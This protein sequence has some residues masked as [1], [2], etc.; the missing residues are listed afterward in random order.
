V[1]TA[2]FF[3]LDGTLLTRE[4]PFDAVLAATFEAELGRVEADWLARYERRFE[5]HA[6]AFVPDPHERALADVCE[7]FDL[8]ADPGALAE[9]LAETDR[10]ATRVSD[11]AVAA[12]RKLGVDDE[13]GVLTNGPRA[14]Q[15]GKLAHHDLQ[16]YFSAVVAA[17]DADARKPDAAIYEAARE[18]VDADEYVM[19]GDDYEADVEGAR[20]AGFVPIHFERE[21]ADFW[22]TLLA[23]L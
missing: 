17:D 8:D 21:G 7:A 11:D 13:L 18:A 12:L 5:A 3:A 2:I 1:A 15:L 22:S 14:W 9:A 20:A 16:G 4:E 23:M 6:A 10:E 19:V